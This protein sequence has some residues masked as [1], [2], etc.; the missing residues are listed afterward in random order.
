M[1]LHRPIPLQKSVEQWLSRLQES[2]GE[3]I[4]TDIYSCIKD[5]DN[6]F[7]FE[8]LVSKVFPKKQQYFFFSFYCFYFSIHVKY[9]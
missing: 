4:R 8:E 2:V 9:H 7:P 1:Q 6:G 3:T 5:I